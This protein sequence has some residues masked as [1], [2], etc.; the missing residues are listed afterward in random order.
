MYACGL[1]IS[2]LSDYSFFQDKPRFQLR[3]L[4]ERFNVIVL[5]WLIVKVV[6]IF[7]S[8]VKLFL[9]RVIWHVGRGIFFSVSNNLIKQKLRSSGPIIVLNCKKLLNFSKTGLYHV[10][11]LMH[12]HTDVSMRLLTK[13]VYLGK[14]G[15]SKY[16]ISNNP[17][18]VLQLRYFL[19]VCILA[20]P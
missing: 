4:C 19:F 6:L 5:V 16:L 1:G 20:K 13:P 18:C 14:F 2:H 15:S 9:R 8:G 3:L 11:S 12:T 17:S 10:K 7:I